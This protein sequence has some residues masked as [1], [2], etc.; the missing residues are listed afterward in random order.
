MTDTP[1][2]GIPYVPEGTLDPAAGLN[3]SLNT[4]DA[5]LQTSVLTIGANAP[6]GSN[7]DGDL[8]IIGTA[9]TGAWAGQANNLARYVAEGNAWQFFVAG[10]QVGLVLNRDDGNLYK[11]DEVNSPQGWVLAAGLSDAPADGQKYARKDET[12]VPNDITVQTDDSPPAVEV[13]SLERLVIGDNLTLTEL[14]PGVA[15]LDATSGGDSPGDSPGGPGEFI[16][17]LSASDLTTDLTTGADK[18][19]FRAPKAFTLV[20]VRAS[21]LTTSSAGAVEVDILKNGVSLLST[22][23]TVDQGELT[24]E[25]AATPA[26]IDDPDVDD[27]DE[28]AINIDAAGT[29]ARGLIITLRGVP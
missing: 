1:N 21:L 8:H 12:W 18:A 5:L 23:L 10:V 6:P 16:Q 14:A 11:F 17:Q 15:R 13:E 26:V 29:G 27:D 19:Y 9:P 2:R 4:I 28:I 24:S 25:T 3:I 20:E 22:A 7:A